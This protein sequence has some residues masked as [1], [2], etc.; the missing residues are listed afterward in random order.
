MMNPR[1]WHSLLAAREA[2]QNHEDVVETI[3]VS[4]E[5]DDLPILNE[6]G[7]N[8]GFFLRKQENRWTHER[9]SEGSPRE[10]CMEVYLSAIIAP[11]V[12]KELGRTIAIGHFAQSLD[13]KIATKSFESKWIGNTEN[14]HH[15]HRMR[16]LCDGIVV[17]NNTFKRDR[18]RLNV[19]HV[20][21]KDPV[22]IIIGQPDLQ[23]E[24][25]LAQTG[26]R[27]IFAAGRSSKFDIDLVELPQK[28]GSISMNDLMVQLYQRDI[29]SVYVEGG[30]YTTSGFL[31]E[32]VLDVVQLHISPIIF[33]SGQ[34]S[35][36]L[37]PIKDVS[38]AIQF[39]QYSFKKVGD[40]YMFYGVINPLMLCKS[41]V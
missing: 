14:L 36:E 2:I 4:A 11:I 15:A 28:N 1:L 6:S 17:G 16:A 18:P 10:A 24:I 5:S 22:K 32:K 8:N 33:G 34:A 20:E 13:G 29:L 30:S 35:F 25:Q 3:W 31:R 37:T 9:R 39:D 21:G 40:S 12:A 26:G 23:T 38:E 27:A 19:R 41:V 7:G